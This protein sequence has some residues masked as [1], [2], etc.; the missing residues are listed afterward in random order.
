MVF[1][2]D[3]GSAVWQRPAQR[4]TTAVELA[5]RCSPLMLSPP[6]RSIMPQIVVFPNPSM[7]GTT[8]EYYL[9]AEWELSLPLQFHFFSSSHTRTQAVYP[10]QTRMKLAR[11]CFVKLSWTPPIGLAMQPTILLMLQSKNAAL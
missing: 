8:N 11:C 3:F 5:A 2:F 7:V 9:D 4:I 6:S 1:S 10:N